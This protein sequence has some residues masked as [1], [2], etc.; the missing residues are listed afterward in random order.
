MREI[1]FK[2]KRKD[3][4]QWVE[5]FYYVHEPPLQCF[6][7]ENNEKPRHT[8]AITAFADW[9]MPRGVQFLEVIPETVSEYTGLTAKN[10]TKAFEG[11]IILHIDEHQNQ[12]RGV[13]KFGIIPLEF[14]KRLK[15]VGFYV[16]LIND[17]ANR[18]NSWLRCD[19]GFW[20]NDQ[21]AEIIGNIHDNPELLKGDADGEGV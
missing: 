14:D 6:P 10:K 12:I 8:I 3:N 21:H 13:I 5:G 4:E 15:N 9:N 17:G 7:D 11:D 18:W 19:I 1:L 20:I 2:A 16:E